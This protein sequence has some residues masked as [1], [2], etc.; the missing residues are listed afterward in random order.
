M[1]LTK[2]SNIPYKGFLD[3]NLKGSN[4]HSLEILLSCDEQYWNIQCFMKY[5]LPERYVT[6][7]KNI[8]DGWPLHNFWMALNFLDLPQNKIF[9]ESPVLPSSQVLDT[10]EVS[11]KVLWRVTVFSCYGEGGGSQKDSVK[12]SEIRYKSKIVSE[13]GSI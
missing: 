12:P 8:V 3:P 9:Q 11:N 13:K 5:P 4:K 1:K 6:K 10:M 7:C 2:I